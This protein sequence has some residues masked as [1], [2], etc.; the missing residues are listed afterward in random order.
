M[1]V[2]QVLDMQWSR[3]LSSHVLRH[4]AGAVGPT[5]LNSCGCQIAQENTFFQVQ[6][7]SVESG[8]FPCWI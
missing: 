6:P 3:V 4:H 5:T 7:D 1:S 8:T 2:L